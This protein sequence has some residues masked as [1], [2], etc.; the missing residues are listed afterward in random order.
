MTSNQQER[1]LTVY[2]TDEEYGVL[3][4]AVREQIERLRGLP[5]DQQRS[6]DVA[7]LEDA[8]DRLKF[9]HVTGDL[10][11]DEEP[12][13]VPERDPDFVIPTGINDGSAASHLHVWHEDRQGFTVTIVATIGEAQN[14]EPILYDAMLSP[15]TV[16][17]DYMIHCAKA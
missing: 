9:A 13:E 12:V 15:D 8:L 3:T 1:E 10:V 5:Q 4:R 11:S 6:D 7:I 2:F 16:L 17:N 14:A